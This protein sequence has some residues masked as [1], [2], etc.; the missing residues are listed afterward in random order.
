[1]N[2]FDVHRHFLLGVSCRRFLQNCRRFMQVYH[3]F[4]HVGAR[5]TGGTGGSTT[6]FL[7]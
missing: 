5:I 6:H 2:A 7:S 4:H 1:M 3:V